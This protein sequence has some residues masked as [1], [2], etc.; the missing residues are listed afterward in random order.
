M[1]ATGGG[2][3]LVDWCLLLWKDVD[4]PLEWRWRAFEWLSNRGLGAQPTAAILNVT[5]AVTSGRD[6]RA[7]SE[8]QLE[9]IDSVFRAAH[10][11][12]V[13]DVEGDE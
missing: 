11:P 10:A 2:Q 1:L 12:K 8:E 13:I 4:A 9:Q 3:E 7:L 6:L 5:N